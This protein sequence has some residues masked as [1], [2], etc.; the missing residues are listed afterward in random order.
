MTDQAGIETRDLWFSYQDGEAA[1]RG[2]SVAIRPG[3]FVAVIGQNGSGKTTLAKHFNGLLRS[4]QGQVLLDGRD[5]RELTVGALARS[6]GYVFQ[7]PDHQIFSATTREEIAFGPT[8]L[9]LAP[10]QIEHS[11]Q[12]ALACFN[13]LPYADRQPALLGY[14]LR[15]KVSIAAVYAMHTPYLVLDEPTTGLDHKSTTELM[16]LLIR[17]NRQGRTIILITH[18]MRVVTEYVPRCIV[19]REGKVLVHDDTRSVFGRHDLLKSTSIEIPQVCELGRRMAM[20]D[21]VLTVAE[22]CERYA[23]LRS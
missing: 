2:V 17:L 5:T 15:R 9:G 19:V 16:Q 11:T 6:V 14:G 10:V 4:S 1:L 21:G 13:L 12:D 22:F 8:N 18:D 7:N 3:E 23:E 20:R